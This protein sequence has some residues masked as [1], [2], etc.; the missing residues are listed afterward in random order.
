MPS[1]KNFSTDYS[2]FENRGGT[3]R[4]KLPSIMSFE[5]A[6]KELEGGFA[7]KSRMEYHDVVNFKSEYQ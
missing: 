1:K 6:D 2:Q 7:P 5:Y 3:R 4:Q